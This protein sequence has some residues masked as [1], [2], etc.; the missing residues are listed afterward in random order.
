[1]KINHSARPG[2]IIRI[3]FL[4]SLPWRYVV[5]S[6]KNLLTE[7]ILMNTHNIPFSNKKENHPKLS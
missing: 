5:C 6:H 1:M 2:R 7:A 4:F 3:Y